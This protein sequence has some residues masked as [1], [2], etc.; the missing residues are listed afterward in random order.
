MSYLNH[1]PNSRR[2]GLFA[3][4][5]PKPS[6]KRA[7]P[8]NT[9]SPSHCRVSRKWL[10]LHENVYD[11]KDCWETRQSSMSL[12]MDMLVMVSRSPLHTRHALHYNETFQE[13]YIST[14]L[15]MRIRLKFKTRLSPSC[16]NLLVCASVL[17]FA[18]M[19]YVNCFTA[20]YRGS[21]SAEHG[22]GA[23]KTFALQYSKSEVSIAWMKKIKQLFDARGIMNP[24]KVLQ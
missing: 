18:V 20:S 5:S 17:S 12:V 6:Q 7:R 24:G 15:R 3:R 8:L 21:V 2:C 23:M 19:S 13:I 9:T 1:P 10:I 16:T 22:I 4:E 14:S 11:L